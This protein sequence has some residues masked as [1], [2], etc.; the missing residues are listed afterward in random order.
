MP[1]C[2][3]CNRASDQ[4]MTKS[5]CLACHKDCLAQYRRAF[6]D[7]HADYMRLYR[8]AQRMHR[9]T[10]SDPP[11]TSNSLQPAGRVQNTKIFS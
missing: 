10:P 9:T 7:R 11:P 1:P 2:T 3:R 8:S 6:I 5:R 4:M